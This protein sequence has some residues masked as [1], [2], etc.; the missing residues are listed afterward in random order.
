MLLP[1][2]LVSCL[3]P[4]EV[5]KGSAPL[6][7]AWRRL[8]VAALLS[9]MRGI[10]VCLGFWPWF[11]L[12]VHDSHLRAATK[13]QAGAVVSNH[14]SFAE[15]LAFC[16]LQDVLPV[17]AAENLRY[18]LLGP[19]F[20]ALRAVPVHRGDA[21]SRAAAGAHIAAAMTAAHVPPV[22]IFP[23]GTAGNGSAVL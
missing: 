4:R 2:A 13:A 15:P 9:I 22:L 6:P 5:V 12:R 7:S 19:I 8:L 3:L 21:K 11:G 23:E 16:A 10:L 18:L 20:C 1:L 17:S 14:V